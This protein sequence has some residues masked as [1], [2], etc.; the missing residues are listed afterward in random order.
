MADPGLQIGI[1]TNIARSH[2]TVAEVVMTWDSGVPHTGVDLGMDTGTISGDHLED[3]QGVLHLVIMEVTM[4]VQFHQC[5]META[6]RRGIGS[7]TIL[8]TL[9]QRMIPL[10]QGPYLL[11]TWS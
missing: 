8:I 2:G 7:P 5:R 11:A 3:L 6:A 4:E 9:T 10:L 1:E